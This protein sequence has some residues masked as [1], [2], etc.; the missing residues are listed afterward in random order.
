MYV[1]KKLPGL[2]AVQTLSRLNRTYKGKN[3]TFIL[4]FVNKVE[5]IQEAFRPYYE[6]TIL[7]EFT[8]P[9]ILYQLEAKINSYGVYSKEDVNR[10][11][12]LFLKPKED[13]RP[14]DRSLI[15]AIIDAGV[16]KFTQF[17]E[18]E[19]DEFKSR[20]SSYTR[21]YSFIL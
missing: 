5:D 7:E 21:F 10:F 1:D 8:D 2:K 13:K 14:R 11:I 12:D 3:D 6:T 4:D 19:Q 18:R 16:S 17:S 20:A 9:N 15:N